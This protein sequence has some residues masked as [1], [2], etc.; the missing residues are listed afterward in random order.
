MDPSPFILE[1]SADNFAALV[2]ENSRLGPVLV[3]FWSSRVGPSLRQRDRLLQLAEAYGG[4]FLLV[5]IDTDQQRGLVGEL[6]VRSLPCC[7]LF[8]HGRLVE[9][10]FGLQPEA[11]YRAL[12]D[13]HLPAVADGVTATALR[14]WQ[15]GDGEGAVRLLAEGALAE[16]ERADLPLLLVKLLMRLGRH[17][18]A[19][20]VLASLPEPLASRP[21]LRRL[22][23]HLDLILAAESAPSAEVL[24]QRLSVDPEDPEARFQLAARQL[25]AD[26]VEGTLAQLAA[27]VEQAPD[28]RSGVA[29]RALAALLDLLDP[30]DERVR[31]YRRSLMNRHR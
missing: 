3:D 19:Q 17:G 8:R 26:D 11:Q 7:K 21:E 1:G 23:A 16:P 12:I 2:L 24:T 15:G 20:A 4:R 28:Y 5:T 22:G 18:E 25:V 14:A 31:R 27:L 10:V 6:G 29:G 30:D 9:Q 13:R